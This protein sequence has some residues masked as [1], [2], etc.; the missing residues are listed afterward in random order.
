MIKPRLLPKMWT[1]SVS[2]L[3][4]TSSVLLNSM[5]VYL[6]PLERKYIPFYLLPTHLT[7]FSLEVVPLNDL[8]L[9]AF[10][11]HVSIDLFATWMSLSSLAL[12]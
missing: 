7:A 3:K 9:R 11:F 12:L 5:A 8:I 4:S 10:I 2:Y 6:G 1:V